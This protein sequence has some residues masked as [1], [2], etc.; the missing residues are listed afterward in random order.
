MLT[1]WQKNKVLFSSFFRPAVAELIVSVAPYGAIWFSP[2]PRPIKVL[3]LELASSP[4]TE[5]SVEL[6]L[7]SS[8]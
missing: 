1:T 6:V 2:R 7:S 3:H 5:H 8:I 4:C